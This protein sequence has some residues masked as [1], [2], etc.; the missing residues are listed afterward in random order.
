MRA[1]RKI[2]FAAVCCG[3]FTLFGCSA[4][5]PRTSSITDPPYSDEES[6]AVSAFEIPVET[7]NSESP[8][9][10]YLGTREP[11]GTA[12]ETYAKTA[13]LGSAESAVTVIY[14]GENTYES[15]LSELIGADE[16]PDLTEKRDNTFPTLMSRNVYED[17]T[18]FM[19]TAAPQWEGLTE[20]IEWYSFK[21]AHCFYPTSVTVSP[22]FLLYDKL[23]YVQFNIPDPEKLWERGEWSWENMISGADI[24][25]E[26]LDIP[27]YIFGAN[28]PDNLLASTGTAFITVDET[29]KFVHRFRSGGFDAVAGLL[30]AHSCGADRDAVFTSADE[31]TLG[32]LRSS[33]PELNIGIVPYPRADNADKYYVKAVTDGYLVPKGAK[34]IRS[35]ASFI[36]CSRIA[37]ESGEHRKTLNRELKAMGLLVS[38]IEWLDIIRSEESAVSVLV[39]E[40]SLGSSANGSVKYILESVMRLGNSTEL[41]EKPMDFDL[42]S[43]EADLERINS[44][45]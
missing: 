12:L 31:Q 6:S 32:V 40:N 19:D 17:L 9:I 23:R 27:D 5:P 42:T 44:M 1:D 34:N 18:P 24:L 11:D 21:D 20:Y 8:Y 33:S 41:P 4:E 29:G 15:K 7:T 43:I 13:G 28:I 22:Q 36:N 2:A 30:G 16:S 35:A 10:T 39:D 38:D 37:E 14:T 3:I 26:S 25:R 45:I